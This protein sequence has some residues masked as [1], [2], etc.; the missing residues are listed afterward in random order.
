M[1]F[2]I[3]ERQRNTAI[4]YPSF[5]RQQ[6][7]MGLEDNNRSCD[8]HLSESENSE[9]YTHRSRQ[10]ESRSPVVGLDWLTSP[11]RKG[12]IRMRMEMKRRRFPRCN[13]GSR[14][15]IH[16]TSSSLLGMIA[17]VPKARESNGFCR[18][19]YLRNPLYDYAVSW[20]G[21]HARCLGMRCGH[22]SRSHGLQSGHAYLDK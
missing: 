16:K 3:G 9:S 5:L 1:R 8:R 2:C 14:Y 19:R 20:A 18:I 11:R 13:L 22:C 12:R 15:W 6:R 21:E 4:A 7:W 10:W 17:R